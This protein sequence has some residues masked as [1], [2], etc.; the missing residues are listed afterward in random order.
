M[1][2]QI[3]KCRDNLW[4]HLDLHFQIFRH[5]KWPHKLDLHF[6]ICRSTMDLHKLARFCKKDCFVGTLIG[7]ANLKMQSRLVGHLDL[8]FQICRYKK[9]PHRLYLHFQIC[10]FSLDLHEL[11]RICKK[12]SLFIIGSACNIQLRFNQEMIKY[13]NS[14]MNNS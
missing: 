11:A 3:W 12:K 10:R 6:Q 1:V 13:W 4:Q 8:H 14:I 5:N 7:S 2:L 9:C